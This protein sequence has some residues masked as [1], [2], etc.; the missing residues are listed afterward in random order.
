MLSKLKDDP[1]NQI[2]EVNEPDNPKGK[3]RYDSL[4]LWS[5][6]ARR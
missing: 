4:I 1:I 3:I 6:T 5:C 2:I